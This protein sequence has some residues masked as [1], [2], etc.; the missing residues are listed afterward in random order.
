MMTSRLITKVPFDQWKERWGITRHPTRE[1]SPK[2]Q[3]GRTHSDRPEIPTQSAERRLRR[4]EPRDADR[5][6]KMK[7]EQHRENQT[8]P[9]ATSRAVDGSKN[10]GTAIFLDHRSRLHRQLIAGRDPRRITIVD[11]RR[12]LGKQRQVEISANVHG[13]KKTPIAWSDRG[14][15]QADRATYGIKGGARR[16][17]V[18][19]RCFDLA[20][21]R[22]GLGGL[23]DVAQS[24]V[25]RMDRLFRRDDRRLAH[26]VRA[27]AAGE[28]Q[29]P[30][31]PRDVRVV[32]AREEH[33]RRRDS[34]VPAEEVVRD[35][36]SSERQLVAKS[37]QP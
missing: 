37:T 9:V 10:F 30:L 22:R 11:A 20:G 36:I 23:R 34:I 16:A 13:T 29:E 35:A 27:T 33:L 32:I 12:K 6:T 19:R 17:G 21:E 28:G 4:D 24:A 1:D 8:Y 26:R 3:T 25:V 15:G 5:K 2:R 14:S 31:A 7:D 18:H